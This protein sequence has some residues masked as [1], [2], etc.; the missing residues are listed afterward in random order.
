[1]RPL[2]RGNLL[3]LVFLRDSLHACGRQASQ[4]LPRNDA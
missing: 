3:Q 4:F 1:M 2:G